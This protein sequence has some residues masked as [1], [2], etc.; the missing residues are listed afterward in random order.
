M[1]EE[2]IA[3]GQ[4]VEHFYITRTSFTGRWNVLFEGTTIGRRRIIKLD[5]EE[6]EPFDIRITAARGNVEKMKV[7]LY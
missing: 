2:D 6:T 1:L 7:T 5:Q 4:R 3:N